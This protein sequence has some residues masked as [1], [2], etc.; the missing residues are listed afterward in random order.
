M[1]KIL[2]KKTKDAPW[3]LEGEVYETKAEAEIY[4]GYATIV[5]HEAKILPIV[6]KSEFKRLKIQTAGRHEERPELHCSAVR[7]DDND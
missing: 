4:L 2:I 3:E 6:S 5:H 1:F 7:L